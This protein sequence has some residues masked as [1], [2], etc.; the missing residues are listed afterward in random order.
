MISEIEKLGAHISLRQA[1]QAA[2]FLNCV[3]YHILHFAKGIH[4]KNK[5]SAANAL[6]C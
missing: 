4:E 2:Y 1:K 6:Q 5:N 3:L